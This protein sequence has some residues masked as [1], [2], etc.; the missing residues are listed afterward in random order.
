[1]LDYLDFVFE[2]TGVTYEEYR[3]KSLRFKLECARAYREYLRWY[4]GK[5]I[6]DGNYARNAID[7]NT[8][9]N[10]INGYI[11]ALEYDYSKAL[12]IEKEA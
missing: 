5:C 4:T 3:V 9:R 2:Y 6:H 12:D 11:E 1:M 8:E 10:K 7:I